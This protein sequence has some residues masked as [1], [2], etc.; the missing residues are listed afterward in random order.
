MQNRVGTNIPVIHN[1]KPAVGDFE[2]RII[3]EFLSEGLISDELPR[4]Y[5]MQL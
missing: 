2:V 5:M 4:S 3:D 1:R